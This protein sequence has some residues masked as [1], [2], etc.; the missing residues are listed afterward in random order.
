MERTLNQ[1]RVELE[2]IATE[3]RQINSFFFGEF[4]DAISQDAVTYPIMIATL[5]P[6]TIDDFSVGVNCIITICDKYNEQEYAQI[7]EIHSD[8]LQICKDIHTTFK[9]WRFEDFMDIN[10]SIATTP[11]INRS[12][13][14]TAG[15]TIT[16]DCTIY[17]DE[18]WCAIP[19]DNYD[20]GNE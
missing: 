7:N 19:Y 8:C 13:D 4:L 18:N 14:L 3:H 16:I 20:F 1:F 9:Q 6:S 11:F 17:D 10:G 15:W 5:Q 2:T 12:Q